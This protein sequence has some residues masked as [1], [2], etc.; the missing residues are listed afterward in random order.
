M[1]KFIYLMV[2]VCTLGFFTACSSDDDDPD[3]WET[4][5][6]G[7]YNVWGEEL[8]TEDGEVD[9]NYWDF[10]MKIEK[11]GNQTAKVTLTDKN[12]EVT[13]NVPEATVIALDGYTLRGQGK[14]TFKEDITRSQLDPS[15][16]YVDFTAKISADYKNISVELKTADGT[17]KGSNSE[18]PAVSKLLATWNLEPVTMYD[19]HGHETEDSYAAYSWKGSFKMNWNISSDS[20]IMITPEL[21]AQDVESILNQSLPMVLKT[22]A[23]TADG[24][25]IAQY[26]EANYTP[27]WQIAED[28]ATYKVVDESKILVFLNNEK[29]VSTITDPAKKATINALLA[30]FKDGIPVNVRFNDIFN[31]AFFYLD[32]A[33]VTELLSNPVI[34]KML[35]IN[36]QD[37]YNVLILKTLVQQLPELMEKTTKFEIGLELMK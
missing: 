1:K 18:K 37:G 32:Q 4:F 8:E 10:D 24:K 14:A 3:V 27:K 15:S 23:F 13:I 2:M 30:V 33:Y 6:A 29:I 35:E 20:P 22:V 5:K 28:Y 19:K 21:S 12:G 26:S 34:V 25:I 9:Y 17:F 11:A 16:M 36:E 7:T 31:T